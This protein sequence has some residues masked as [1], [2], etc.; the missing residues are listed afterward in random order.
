[1]GG[2]NERRF[3][4]MTAIGV[5][6]TTGLRTKRERTCRPKCGNGEFTIRGVLC[7]VLYN[8]I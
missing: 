4:L 6:D 7:D 2:T 3:R 5:S 1:M 8:E